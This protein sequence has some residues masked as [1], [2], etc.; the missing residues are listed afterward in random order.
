MHY[1]VTH[2]RFVVALL[3]VENLKRFTQLITSSFHTK[4]VY[5]KTRLAPTPSGYLHLGNVFSF[6]LTMALAK[7]T[8]AKVLLRIDDYDRERVAEK[9]IQDIFDTLHFLEISWDEGPKNAADFAANYAQRHRMHL[10]EAALQSLINTRQVFA[11]TCSRTQISNS[12]N[13]GGYPGTCRYKGIALQTPYSALRLY[14]PDSV[15]I[16]ISTVSGMRLEESLPPPVQDFVVQKKDGM[17][18]YQ[19]CSVADDLHFEVDMIVRGADL[20][21][22]TLAQLYLSQILKKDAFQK[23]TFLHHS[24]LLDGGKKM[25]K[26]AGA[27]SVCQLRKEGK[28]RKDIYAAIARMLHL[29]TLSVT[30]WQSLA[31]VLEHHSFI[32]F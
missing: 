28:K 8:G 6:V 18:A 11:C 29:D 10:Y 30:D 13:D 31:A 24:L 3:T 19:L 4:A 16:P 20:W 17:P 32:A 26:S 2:F 15:V 12:N 7:K 23:A 9:Y 22:S 1:L 25:S 21:P 14:T 27:T 5:S